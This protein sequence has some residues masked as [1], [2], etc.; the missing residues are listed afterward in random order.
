VQPRPFVARSERLTTAIDVPQRPTSGPEVGAEAPEGRP[1]DTPGG[2]EKPPSSAGGDR[3]PAPRPDRPESTP[4]SSKSAS[5]DGSAPSPLGDKAEAG[6]APGGPASSGDAP[7]PASGGGAS[8]A[9]RP[10]VPWPHSGSEAAAEPAGE[11]RADGSA[12]GEAP[13]LKSNDVTR[14]FT[15]GPEPTG[16]GGSNGSTPEAAPKKGAH[17]LHTG[18]YP[19]VSESVSMR[20]R[21]EPPPEPA[22]LFRPAA[23]AEKRPTPDTTVKVPAVKPAN[24]VD[25]RSLAPVP[26]GAD[27][28]DGR[29]R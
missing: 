9:E 3:P 21:N 14:P 10:D 22:E 18:A 23:R 11:P 15:P 8:A 19:V 16:S 29:S 25:G 7:K 2:A 27:K 20:P 12:S 26:P 1:S 13:R 24:G 28:S 5:A 17:A 6:S 4:S